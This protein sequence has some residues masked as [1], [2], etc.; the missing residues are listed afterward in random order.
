MY[1]KQFDKVWIYSSINALDFYMVSDYLRKIIV[2]GRSSKSTKVGDIMTEEVSSLLPLWLLITV[3]LQVSDLLVTCVAY[4]FFIICFANRTSSS[5]WL[6]ILKFF[7]QCNWWL[8]HNMR[9]SY[10]ETAC[11]QWI[12]DDI[13]C[14]GRQPYQAHSCDQWQGYDWNGL[15]RRRCSS[16]GKWAPGGAGPPERIYPGRLL[17]VCSATM[18]MMTTKA[19]WCIWSGY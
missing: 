1:L 11:Y 7:G 12:D 10:T 15:H 19:S 18:L 3:Q 6:P 9:W 14:F 16:G 5:Q 8:V 2:Q 17:S 4:S 13:V